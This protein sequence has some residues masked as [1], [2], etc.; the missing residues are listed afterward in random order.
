VTPY[1]LIAGAAS[2]FAERPALVEAGAALSYLDMLD[3]VEAASRRLDAGGLG[4]GHAV[5]IQAANCLE[6]VVGILASAKLGATI[7][8]LD[9]SLKAGEVQTYCARTGAI[10]LLRRPPAGAKAQRGPS[11]AC[12]MPSVELLH[13]EPARVGRSPGTAS[14][15]VRREGGEFLL[16][17][18]GTTGAPKIVWRS[19]AQ[20]RAA[21]EI[22]TETLPCS[23]DDR[24]LAVLPFFHSFGLL[25]VLLTTL[26]RGAA[27]HLASFSPR[28]TAKAIQRDR[29]TVLPATPFMF[30]ILAETDFRSAPD[31]S[32][33]RLAVSAGSALPVAIARRFR[34]K[35]GVDIVQSYGTTESGPVALAWPEARVDEP[36]W[37]GRPYRG[38]TVEIWDRSGEPARPGAQGEI[39][40]ESPANA[41]EYL[42]DPGASAGT[43]KRGRV[44]TGD[45]GTMNEAGDV[46]VLGRERPMLSVAGKKVAPAEV[47]ACLR[48]HPCVA[49]VVVVGLRTPEG[50]ERVKAIVVAAGEVTALELREFCAG[51]LAD[52]KAPRIVEFVEN[53]SRGPMDKAPTPT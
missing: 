27:L 49:D 41:S 20:V 48:R 53:L 39:A 34:D 35:F 37:V 24:V 26:S 36:G 33:L 21:L 28:A 31:L 6:C 46:F 1:E 12:P 22:F 23:E 18:S 8:L 42:G 16:L 2:R 43:F 5:A 38:V 9:P 50:D 14:P 47:E 3:A 7:L 40:V 10:M 45:L 44:L 17:S 25:N 15:P 11:T 4:S 19:S 30:R 13:K 51:Q 32:S 29:I 52:F